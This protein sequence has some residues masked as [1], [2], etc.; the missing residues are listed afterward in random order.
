MRLQT[1]SDSA[2]GNTFIQKEKKRMEAVVQ[3]QKDASDT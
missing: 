3:A 1:K 2:N